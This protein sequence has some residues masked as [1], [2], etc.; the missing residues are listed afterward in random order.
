MASFST[1]EKAKQIWILAKLWDVIQDR[2]ETTESFNDLIFNLLEQLQP[3][4]TN[5]LAI[6]W[7]IWKIRNQKIWENVDP[8]PSIVVLTIRLVA[9]VSTL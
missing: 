7:C 2:F 5:Q 3:H 1:C 9:T 4:E 8:S 6:L